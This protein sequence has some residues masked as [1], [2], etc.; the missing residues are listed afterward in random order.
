MSGL[1]TCET[2]CT[3]KS[4]VIFKVVLTNEIVEK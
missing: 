2:E 3:E 1:G 4:A